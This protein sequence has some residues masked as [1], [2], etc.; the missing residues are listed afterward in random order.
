MG[1]ST[2]PPHNASLNDGM[3]YFTYSTLLIYE[4]L[5]CSSFARLIL[6]IGSTI[7]LPCRACAVLNASVRIG[8]LSVRIVMPMDMKKLHG[9]ISIAR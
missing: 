2:L 4:L 6:S 5:I 8:E 7:G 9:S 3:E 1:R